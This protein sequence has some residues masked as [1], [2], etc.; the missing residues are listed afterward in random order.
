[1]TNVDDNNSVSVLTLFDVDVTAGGVY[2]CNVNNAA[3]NDTQ[4]IMVS[5][6]PYFLIQ[7]LDRTGTNNESEVI[8]EC[9]AA[10]FPEPEYMWIRVDGD[11]I[12]GEVTGVNSTALVFGPGHL[13]GS[14]GDYFCN[15]SSG[16]T[17]IQSEVATLTGKEFKKE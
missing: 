4:D 3:G 5:I 2:S 13:F 6:S 11:P 1:M 14:E 9:E 10:A 7:P 17:S 15:V 16:E 8:L 12:D